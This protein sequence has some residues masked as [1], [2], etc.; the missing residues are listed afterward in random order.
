MLLASEMPGDDA[1][2]RCMGLVIGDFRVSDFALRPGEWVRVPIPRGLRSEFAEALANSLS[3]PRVELNSTIAY[4]RPRDLATRSRNAAILARLEPRTAIQK[5]RHATGLSKREAKALF[6]KANVPVLEFVRNLDYFTDY[7]LRLAISTFE[8]RVILCDA[9]PRFESRKIVSAIAPDHAIVE[10]IDVERDTS[11]VVISSENLV[12]GELQVPNFALCRGQSIR[13]VV[14]SE[15]RPELAQALTDPLG[16]AVRLRSCARY[17]PSDYEELRT[18][19]NRF[20]YRFAP[21]TVLKYFM[22]RTGATEG[23]A[24]WYLTLAKLRPQYRMKNYGV[25]WCRRLGVAIA[26]AT[27]SVIVYDSWNKPLT[28]ETVA[29]IAT[30]HAII[31]LDFP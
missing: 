25:D 8:G 2:I 9:M 5:L 4:A 16:K 21:P 1:L 6:L 30:N 10:M 13:I 24:M 12:V 17:A 20:E 19:M 7:R 31:E 11:E 29:A 3:N 15:L 14:P 23:E 26:A 18:T 22:R 27:A 28:R